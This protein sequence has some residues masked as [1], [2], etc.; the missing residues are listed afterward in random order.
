MDAGSMAT[1]DL[2]YEADF[3]ESKFNTHVSAL[4]TQNHTLREQYEVLD[5]FDP[6]NHC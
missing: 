2:H 1:P 5:I 4:F 6:K 3:S